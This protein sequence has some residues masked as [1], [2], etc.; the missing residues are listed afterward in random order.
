MKL[1]QRYAKIGVNVK[2]NLERT[3]MAETENGCRRAKINIDAHFAGNPYQSME[4]KGNVITVEVKFQ[5]RSPKAL[6]GQ[7]IYLTVWLRPYKFEN[8]RD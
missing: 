3:K 8:I 1:A 4:L 7:R 5:K 6:A 2:A